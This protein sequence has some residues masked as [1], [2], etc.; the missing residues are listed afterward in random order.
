MARVSGGSR[1]TKELAEFLADL[2]V[3]GAG[4]ALRL[5]WTGK[6]IVE[7]A[8]LG[9]PTPE[10]AKFGLASAGGDFQEGA[11]RFLREYLGGESRVVP[12]GGRAAELAELRRW[13]EDPDA[14]VRGLLTAPAGRGKS[15]LVAR[16]A[17]DMAEREDVDLL[18]LPVSIRFE[19]N[20]EHDFWR[21]FAVGLADIAKLDRH[22][23]SLTND[24]GDGYN[25]CASLREEHRAHVH[26]CFIVS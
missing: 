14:P 22:R 20:A 7:G 24:D 11:E 13:V 26:L 12:F 18:F 25:D 4:R 9:P 8:L 10:L 3:S 16:F 23:S 17:A 15:A 1:F 2:A 5:L 19:T 6:E 21:A